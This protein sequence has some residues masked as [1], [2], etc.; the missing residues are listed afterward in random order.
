MLNGI[1][2]III[3][4]IPPTPK[5]AQTLSGIPVVGDLVAQGVPIPIYLDE[6]LTG[7]YVSS[8]E[9]SIDIDNDVIAKNAGGAEVYQ[10]PL[11]NMV[12]VN[13]FA[14]KDSTA[15]VVLLAMCDL[16]FAKLKYGYTITYLN[17]PVIIF[18]GLLKTFSTHTSTEDDL[19]RIVLQLSKATVRNTTKA[20]NANEGATKLDAVA[21]VN[22]SSTVVNGSPIMVPESA[23]APSLKLR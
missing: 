18:G 9:K 6:K 13:L 14:K 19:I 22:E 8:E 16:V 1:A 23:T 21:G 15:L 10:N 3:F 5:L 4:T 17:G 7:V 12:T 11:D 20:L 2:P